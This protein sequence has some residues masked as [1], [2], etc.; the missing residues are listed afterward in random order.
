[1]K[2]YFF[3]SVI[4][5]LFFLL[6]LYYSLPY[7]KITEYYL[8]SFN[9]QSSI[10]PFRPSFF[11]KFSVEKFSI[12]YNG[13]DIITDNFNIKLYPFHIFKLAFKS[14]LF[15]DTLQI[16]KE[17]IFS[18]VL[19]NINL[20]NLLTSVKYNAEISIKKSDLEA[21]ENS[22]SIS[23]IFATIESSEKLMDN[24]V[25][26]LKSNEMNALIKKIENNIELQIE[27]DNEFIRQ[28]RRLINILPK[29]KMN[30]N[31]YYDKF[32]L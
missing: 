14:S 4:F 23:E 6:F 9:V 8:A 25:F 18:V 22:V 17:N 1:M 13:Y 5:L 2:K 29:N 12:N 26:L 15:I 28:E 27:F 24:I 3:Y 32:K 10:S 30:K 19:N 7:E 21:L 31:I 11:K 20:T 16:K